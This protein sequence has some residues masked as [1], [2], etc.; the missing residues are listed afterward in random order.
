MKEII[1]FDTYVTKYMYNIFFKK[2]PQTKNFFQYSV[3]LGH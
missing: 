3:Q 1:I 2:K